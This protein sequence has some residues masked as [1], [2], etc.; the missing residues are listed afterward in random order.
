MGLYSCD[1]AEFEYFLVIL[2]PRLVQAI[3]EPP[4]F[5]AASIFFA[6]KDAIQSA[7]SDAG[8]PGFFR[9]DSPATAERIRMACQDQFT[10]QVREAQ[11]CLSPWQPFQLGL[12]MC[13]SLCLLLKSV[14]S[15]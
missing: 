15:K 2:V 6:I 9:L 14:T 5:L 1:M 4:L 10:Q 3:G 7:R 13:L 11:V 12:F 8:I